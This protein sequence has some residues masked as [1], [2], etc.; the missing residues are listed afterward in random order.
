MW[1]KL[2][3]MMIFESVLPHFNAFMLHSSLVK[4][5]DSAIIF[6]APSGTG[7]ST[8]ANL[9]VK[10]ENARVLNGDRSI[11]RL[12]EDGWYAYGSPWTGTSQIYVNDSAKIG[13]LIILKQAPYNKLTKMSPIE[14]AKGVISEAM[15]PYWEENLLNISLELVE[16][17]ITDIPVYMLECLPDK[18]AVEIV[19][20]ML[21]QQKN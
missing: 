18:G 10:Y 16:K 6:S 20:E 2:E 15:M 5:K 14:A 3:E 4:Y 1:A 8:Q 9:W 19:K 7:K 13:A 12:K 21:L 17:F 11:L